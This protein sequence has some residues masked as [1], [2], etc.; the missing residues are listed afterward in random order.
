[1]FL[2]TLLPLCM[3]LAAQAPSKAPEPPTEVVKAPEAPAP[4][5]DAK[6][7]ASP[8]VPAPKA[9]PPPRAAV[10]EP[11]KAGAQGLGF[12]SFRLPFTWNAEIPVQ[13]AE[14]DG[15]RIDSIYFNKRETTVWPLKGADFGTRAKVKVT[16][17]SGRSRVPGFAVAVF[18]AEDR[19][20]GVATGGTKIG[21]VS[22]G[23]TETFDLNFR[24]V[25]ERLPKGA[26][27]FLSVE[28]G[29]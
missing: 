2:P 7:P 15:L 6:A 11:P 12:A 25:L 18:D 8:A 20:V 1:M 5:Q 16:N 22:A 27:F 14:V 23:S 4:A 28:L 29:D 9:V 21:T 10:P 24:Y 26:T 13:G 17:T 19:L 3:A